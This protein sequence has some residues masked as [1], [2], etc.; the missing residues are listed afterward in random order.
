[1]INICI[2]TLYYI[3][4]VCKYI[5]MYIYIYLST[6]IHQYSPLMLLSSPQRK[7]MNHVRSRCFGAEVEAV[8][9]QEAGCGPYYLVYG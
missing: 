4:D 8:T 6:Y 9:W 2:Y 7:L 5:H 3:Y 1:M